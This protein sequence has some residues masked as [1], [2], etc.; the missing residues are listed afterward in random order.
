M[1]I[2]D[3]EAELNDLNKYPD[4]TSLKQAGS[5]ILTTEDKRKRKRATI[6]K[7]ILR[8]LAEEQSIMALGT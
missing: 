7:S 5:S 3:V 6:I 4:V 8:R 1:K 2:D